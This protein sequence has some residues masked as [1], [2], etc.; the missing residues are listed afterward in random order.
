MSILC[1]R[2]NWLPLVFTVLF[3]LLLITPYPFLFFLNGIVVLYFR[4]LLA[5]SGCNQSVCASLGELWPKQNGMQWWHN[6]QQHASTCRQ[7][8]SYPDRMCCYS[9]LGTDANNLRVSMFWTLTNEWHSP[10]KYA[11]LSFITK[12]LVFQHNTR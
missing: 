2:N 1:L 11:F 12:M 9:R 7:G 5:R 6:S 10:T 4:F 8:A 3:V